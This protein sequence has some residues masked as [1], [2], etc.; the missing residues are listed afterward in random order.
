MG[1]MHGGISGEE[2]R[3]LDYFH[4]SLSP[5]LYREFILDFILYGYTKETFVTK[6]DKTDTPYC[7]Y[8]SFFNYIK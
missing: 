7:V 8:G 1:S 4:Q 2:L 3:M 5:M 6:T